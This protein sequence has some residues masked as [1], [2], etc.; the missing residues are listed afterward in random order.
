LITC[1]GRRSAAGATRNA[2]K[3]SRWTSALAAVC[4]SAPEFTERLGGALVDYT[5]HAGL[6]VVIDNAVE[7]HRV[8]VIDGDRE[9]CLVK[10]RSAGE[11]MDARDTLFVIA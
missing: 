1:Y 4:G 5:D 8:G 6:A 7:E 3:R 11:L 2:T 10:L 9:E